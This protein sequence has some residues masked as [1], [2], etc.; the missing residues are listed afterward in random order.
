MSN[1]SISDKNSLMSQTPAENETQRPCKGLA[2]WTN[3]DQE[4]S[5]SS[6]DDLNLSAEV[7]MEE[8]AVALWNDEQSD[9]RNSVQ[10]SDAKSSRPTSLSSI[11]KNCK[12]MVLW[13]GY[14]PT[15]LSLSTF[16][17]KHDTQSDEMLEMESSRSE[18]ETEDLLNLHSVDGS[19]Q[20]EAQA[21]V[22]AEEGILDL[23]NE[24]P[25]FS[26]DESPF[27]RE[28]KLPG[29]EEMTEDSS[30]VSPDETLSNNESGLTSI[31]AEESHHAEEFNPTASSFIPEIQLNAAGPQGRKVRLIQLSSLWLIASSLVFIGFIIFSNTSSSTATSPSKNSASVNSS[32]PDNLV[33]NASSNNNSHVELPNDAPLPS[34]G[35]SDDA[36]DE[37]TTSANANETVETRAPAATPAIVESAPVESNPPDNKAIQ[38]AAPFAGGFTTQVS[39][40][41][42]VADSNKRVADLKA[43]GFEARVVK[44]DVPKRGTWYRV[45]VGMFA[46]RKEAE[47]FGIQLKSKGA[48]TD[49]IVTEAGAQ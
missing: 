38:N 31:S 15:T 24:F 41:Q 35:R 11:Q 46:S 47:A 3:A 25:S 17:Q 19:Q 13:N 8:K 27:V 37:V 26:Q 43:A 29:Q 1:T 33:S 30:G 2:L 28:A 32:K 49:V 21:A 42:N 22:V 10:N 39:S 23:E 40:S 48:A 6:S 7:V 12:D 34:D 20:L 45:Q 5:R 4:S 44:V 14:E 16:Q 36:P 9:R 18:D